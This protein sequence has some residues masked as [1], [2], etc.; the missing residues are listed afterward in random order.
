MFI[1]IATP[2]NENIIIDRNALDCFHQS[3]YPPGD[4]S[5]F[6]NRDIKKE[7][8]IHGVVEIHFTTI[9]E[10]DEFVMRFEKN[11]GLSFFNVKIK[12]SSD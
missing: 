10:R 7:L 4:K 2:K 5:Y 6:K 9:D 8:E 1:F 3:I 11:N 12:N